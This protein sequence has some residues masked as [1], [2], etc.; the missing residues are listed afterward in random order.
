MS[1]IPEVQ[2]APP[3][4]LDIGSFA[5]TSAHVSTILTSL[6]VIILAI[7]IR[8]N[9]GVRP[10]KAQVIYESMMDFILDK[11]E[12]P[13]GSRERALK[14]FP[15]IFTIF[16]FLLIANQLLLLPFLDSTTANVVTDGTVKVQNLFRLPTSHYS[17][18]I[19]LTLLIL[20]LSHVLAFAISPIRHIGNYIKIGQFFKIKSIKDL[21]MAFLDLFLGLLDII[22]EFAKLASL[23]TRLFGNMFAGSIVVGI[24]GGLTIFTRYLIPM[25]FVVLGILSGVVQAFVFTMLSILYISSSLNAVKKPEE[26]AK[27]S[28][29][30]MTNQTI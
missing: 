18:P 11:M 7:I 1:N 12:Q 4:I 21:P 10:S 22:G 13:F 15:L 29:L 5:V 16:F 17:A 20:I 30:E 24:I 28:E 6:I 2:I 3:A 9:S 25:P 19:A 27:V 26:E 8:K 14:F 23:S